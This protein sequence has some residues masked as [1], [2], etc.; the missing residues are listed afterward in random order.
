MSN[1]LVYP[2]LRAWN[3]ALWLENS[4]IHLSDLYGALN[5]PGNACTCGRRL[6]CTSLFNSRL[7]NHLYAAME[8]PVDSDKPGLSR[9][10]RPIRTEERLTKDFL[11][12]RQTFHEVLNMPEIL[13]RKERLL[14]HD[15]GRL[16]FLA[17]CH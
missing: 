2:S 11:R 16:C 1:I 12:V 9:E 7:F 15:G 5:F 6:E 17:S 4:V 14:N 8:L 3:I 13:Q 10:P